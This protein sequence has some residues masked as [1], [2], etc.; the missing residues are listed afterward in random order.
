MT[1][2]EL[3]EKVGPAMIHQALDAMDVETVQRFHLDVRG[4]LEAAIRPAPPSREPPAFVRVTKRGTRFFTDCH[5]H[6]KNAWCLHTAILVLYHLGDSVA[7]IDSTPARPKAMSREADIGFELVATFS[8]AGG[9]FS[10]CSRS[11]QRMVRKP[12]AYLSQ[13]SAAVSVAPDEAALLGELAE[14]DGETAWVVARGDLAP[15]LARLEDKQVFRKP[16]VRW[17]WRRVS[18]SPVTVSVALNPEALFVTVQWHTQVSKQDVL[19]PGRPGFLIDGQ[20]IRHCSDYVPDLQAFL[21][22]GSGRHELSPSPEWV[23][24]LV[25]EKHGVSWLTPKPMVIRCLDHLELRLRPAQHRLH[26]VLGVVA[27]GLFFPLPDDLSR[28]RLV[29]CGKRSALLRISSAEAGRIS[30]DRTKLRVPWKHGHFSLSR[31]D[32]QRLLEKTPMP[33]SWTVDRVKA[34]G[35]FGMTQLEVSA[36]WDQEGRPIYRIGGREYDHGTLMY[37][38]LENKSGVRLPNGQTLRFDTTSLRLHQA[39]LDGV[40]ALHETSAARWT[41]L[42]RIIH[43]DAGDSP[44]PVAL[45]PQLDR[46]LREYQRHGVAWLLGN[47]HRQEP[48]LLADD[49]GL[50][51]TVQTLAY[52]ACTQPSQPQL[53][54]TPKSVL[55]NW[56]RECDR[57]TPQRRVTR[58]HGPSRSKSSDQ[59]QQADLLLTTYGTLRADLDLLEHV[60]FQTIVLDEAQAIKNPHAQTA[61]AVRR[62]KSNHR[63]ALT[64]TPIENTLLELWSIFE[65]LAPSY[66]GDEET[67]KHIHDVASVGYRAVKAKIQPFLLRRLKSQVEKD[68]PEKQEIV[69]H[70]PLEPQQ[71]ALYESIRRDAHQWLQTQ[72]PS[73]NTFN[74][75]TK[76]LRLRQVCCHPGLV[77]EAWVNRPSSK[78][79]FIV[80]RLADLAA[81][82]HHALVFSQFTQLLK[83]LRFELEARDLEFLYLDGATENRMD[84]VDR[85][86]TGSVPVFLISL[87]AGG[88]GLN[89]TRA[90]YVFHLDP[91]WN[92]MVER[93]ATDRTHRIGQS[94]RV[95]SYK[96]IT[97][98][99]VEEKILALQKSKQDL[100][101]GMFASENSFINGLSQDQLLELFT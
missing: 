95:L 40:H 84:L 52:L 37:G 98:G 80:Q 94:K 72:T 47:H 17:N 99:T 15:V 70:L 81:S 66:L 89:L 88:T 18:G 91:W 5:V 92:P 26:G 64:G 3:T 13:H 28:P 9:S 71:A 2:A 38:L 21:P 23:W 55:S 60:S 53:V 69:V 25:R 57:F 33:E 4:R 83:L 58:H 101:E 82:G 67:V 22:F 10:L 78:L 90:A 7:P 50:G 20:S 86:Q 42:R 87:K 39:L 12:L 48:A 36:R 1:R 65:F 11:T 93:Q 46:M 76:L 41:V 51:K 75:L 14:E 29:W 27:G 19:I 44:K 96:L 24:P 62:L 43:G 61:R 63:V 6:G 56:A 85:F 77:D 79:T 8:E 16:Q 35:W 97:E 45:P 30:N 74:I 54:V 68:L 100:A 31:G 32:A 73:R 49:M 34:D 59:L